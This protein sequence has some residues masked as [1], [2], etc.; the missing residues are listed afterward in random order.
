SF[1]AVRDAYLAKIYDDLA[2]LDRVALVD[3]VAEFDSRDAA[4]LLL[5]SVGPLGDKVDDL[6]EK[7]EKVEKDHEKINSNQDIAGDGFEKLDR[8]REKIKKFD[9]LLSAERQVMNR[10]LRCVKRFRAESARAVVTAMAIKGK[11]W[12]QRGMSARASA[13]YPTEAGRKAAIKALEDKV[14]GVLIHTLI[15]LRERKD[16]ETVKAIVPC[17]D[18]EV[19]VVQSAAAD[20]L[21][22][23][24]SKKAIRPLIEAIART[25][26]RVQDDINEALKKLTGE[27]Y[28]PDYERW[29]QWYEEHRSELEEEEAKPLAKGKKKKGEEGG[30]HYYGIET[31]SK[32]IVYVID[33]SGSMNKE[34][35]GGKTFTPEEGKK[36]LPSGPKI[37]IA[38]SELKSAIRGL[39]D[40]A[41]FNIIT[42]NQIVK[43]WEKEML[44]ATQKNKNKA[45]LF[46]RKLKAAGSTYTYG[47]L[48]EAFRLAGMGARDASYDS[49][50]DTIFLL[51]DGAPTDQSFP[52][53]KLMDPAI[54][55]KAV[56]EWN[57]LRK[58]VIHAIAIDPQIS[59][60][61]FIRF[62]RDLARQNGG[63]YT[64]RG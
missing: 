39:P 32:R 22:E 21:A 36:P 23:I 15:G 35:R 54:I 62:M 37:E 38:K 51:S 45:Y 18:H 24:A 44:K 12:R 42:F 7:L 43:R 41:Y 63:Q 4:K 19:W 46:I 20:A 31:R 57:Q 40:D 11:A 3:Q 8:L 5:E 29:K 27:N 2:A 10:I 17:L 55:L 25:E 58:V 47:A 49:L 61:A 16:A 48:K 9:G 64:E 50:V 6:L 13:G 33:I 52:T 34:I 53:A 30:S 56:K 14:A 28:P 1:T 26:G 59:G 60:K